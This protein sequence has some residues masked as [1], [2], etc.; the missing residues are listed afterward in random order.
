[1]AFGYLKSAAR[2]LLNIVIPPRCGGCSVR[3]AAQPGL[4]ADCFSGLRHISAPLCGRCG[5]PFADGFGVCG[6]GC[7][8]QGTLLTMGRS[9]L[10]YDE[11]SKALILP[12]KRAGRTD[13]APMLALLLLQAGREVLQGADVL[14]PVPLHPL[15]LLRRRYNQS[16][17]LAAALGKLS[18]HRVMPWALKRRRYTAQQSGS[19]TARR[20]N[21]RG[22]FAVRRD[23]RG[24]NVVLIDDVLTS[25]ATLE[26]CAAAL[27]N[28]GAARVSFLTVA[29]TR[30]AVEADDLASESFAA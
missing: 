11:A 4:C 12:F 29:R 18:D 22:V 9:A 24:L 10:V 8:M 14:I 19:H 28:A 1:M 7:R 5:Q 21:V 6:A 15:R 26:A 16:Q 25:G 2:A 17:L 30:A 23:V 13:L 27:I 3:I 20:R